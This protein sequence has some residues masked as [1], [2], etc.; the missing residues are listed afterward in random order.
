MT[1]PGIDISYRLLGRIA[2]SHPYYQ[3]GACTNVALRPVPAAATALA[4]EGIRIRALSSGLEFWARADADLSK[5]TGPY[6]FQLVSDV[7]WFGLL[8]QMGAADDIPAGWLL[9][10]VF[11]GADTSLDMAKVP[12][13]AQQRR[14]SR[15]GFAPL[16]AAQ[17]VT[18]H[19]FGSRDVLAQWRAV[20]GTKW[21][22]VNLADLPDAGYSLRVSGRSLAD[23]VLTDETAP[24]TFGLLQMTLPSDGT[25]F[26]MQLQFARRP[27]RWRYLF[28][29]VDDPGL[30]GARVTSSLPGV[31][32]DAPVAVD[33]QSRPGW[34]VISTGDVPLFAMPSDHHKVTLT[35]DP[36]DAD[37]NGPKTLPTPQPYMI[38][39][40]NGAAGRAYWCTM[41]V[42]V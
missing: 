41:Y 1:G 19:P 24:G 26:D 23:F 10:A 40:E 29:S 34:Q 35:F 32:F 30:A 16:Q 33:V 17:D 6:A 21:L 25:V 38:R 8:S 9:S 27:V 31:T 39:R 11:D 37:G 20:A 4:R 18:L 42:R 12:V 13:L 2:F 28:T 22:D 15:I 3:D 7:P 14:K 36:D 5:A